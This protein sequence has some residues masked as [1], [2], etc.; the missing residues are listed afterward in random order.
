MTPRTTATFL[1]VA[2]TLLVVALTLMFVGCA[3]PPSR[4]LDC[5]QPGWRVATAEERELL[6]KKGL[7]T[8]EPV[9]VREEDL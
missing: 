3:S 5:T 4:P 9:C 2:L 8:Q 1:A 7:R 6:T